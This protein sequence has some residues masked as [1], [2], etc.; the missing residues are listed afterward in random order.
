MWGSEVAESGCGVGVWVGCGWGVG[1]V[2]VGC[3]WGVDG[4]WLI[5]WVVLQ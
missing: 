2:W 5:N 3:G 4:V 1:G